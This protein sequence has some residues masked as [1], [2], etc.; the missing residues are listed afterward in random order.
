MKSMRPS[1][2]LQRPPAYATPDDQPERDR[3]VER[4]ERLGGALRLERIDVGEDGRR[5]ERQPPA[6]ASVAGVEPPLP[7]EVAGQQR[8]HEEAQVAGVEP[9]V[10]VEVHAE[11]RRHLDRHGRGHGERRT[12]RWRPFAPRPAAPRRR[13][14]TRRVAS[15]GARSARAR[16]R[17]RGRRGRPCASPRPG[18][19]RRW[20]APRRPARDLLAQV[21]LQLRHVDG[22]DRL[23]AAE[24]APPLVDL[25]LERDTRVLE[26]ASSGSLRHGA[27]TRLAGRECERRQMPR[28]VASTACHCRRSSAS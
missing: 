10:L 16:T 21:V 17:A 22:V 19:P 6:S 27:A 20:R 15:R 5:D 14:G 3:Q 28:S 2:W 18:T 23:P 4:G 13:R 7:G 25:L 8:Q 12:R 11:E 9:G 1:T 24:V 26:P